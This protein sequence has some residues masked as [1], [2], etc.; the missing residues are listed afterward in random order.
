[1]TTVFEG[2][3]AESKKFAQYYRSVAEFYKVNFLDTSQFLKPS[4]RWCAFRCSK[5]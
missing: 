4:N 5:Q 2:A 1:M 3:E